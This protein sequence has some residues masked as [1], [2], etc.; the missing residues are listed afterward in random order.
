M[1]RQL[2]DKQ[3]PPIAVA[4]VERFLRLEAMQRVWV[5]STVP[6]RLEWVCVFFSPYLVDEPIKE[7]FLYGTR[8]GTP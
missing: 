7:R 1:A 6:E 5:T 8:E 2:A 4:A 3:P